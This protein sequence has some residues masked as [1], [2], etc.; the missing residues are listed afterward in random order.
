MIRS[1][2]GWLCLSQMWLWPLDK[3]RAAWWETLSWTVSDWGYLIWGQFNTNFSGL[4]IIGRGLK[5]ILVC[6]YCCCYWLWFMGSYPSQ[7]VS[8]RR[9]YRTEKLHKVC[10]YMYT[11]SCLEWIGC[12]WALVGAMLFISLSRA[13]SCSCSD[14]L[15]V[16]KIMN[17]F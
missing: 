17:F 9:V 8:F 12:F 3:E 7:S 10:L 13:C 5:Y 16:P 14:V 4:C 15:S 11:V 1:F 6:C 2:Q